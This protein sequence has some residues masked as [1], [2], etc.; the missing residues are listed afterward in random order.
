MVAQLQW[1]SEVAASYETDSHAQQL[2]DKLVVDPAT[3]QHFSFRDG[4]LRYKQRVWI[5]NNPKLQTRIIAALHDSVVGGHS[6][7]PVTYRRIKQLFAWTGLK[8][9][10]QE[11]AHACVTYQRAKP[12]CTRLPGLLQPVPNRA[13]QV[14][15]MDFVEGLPL[16]G[17]FNCILVIVDTFSKYAHFLGLKHPFTA[18]TVAKLFVTQVY[19]LHGLSNAIMS[20]RDR[21]FTSNMLRELFKLA[22]VTLCVSSAYHP[23]SDGQTEWVNQC[24]EAYLWCFVHACPRQW[25]NWLDLT[26]FW[27]NTLLHSSLGR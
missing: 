14:I 17:G 26:E 1:L 15:S 21:I 20:D 2:I 4:L 7:I 6:G 24:L 22:G 12:D 25:S 10:V 13:W 19:K 9:A 27:Y 3:V 8:S 11:F 5:G 23:Q 18:A 16:S